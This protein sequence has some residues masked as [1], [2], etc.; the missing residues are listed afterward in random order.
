MENRINQQIKANEVRLVSLPENYTDGVYPIAKAI[1]I[2]NILN[3]DLIEISPNSTPPVCKIMEFSKFLYEKKK[4]EKENK[5]NQKI[6]HLKEIGL[7]P[8]IGE[9]DLETKARKGNEFLKNGDKIKVVLLFKGRTIVFKER[10]ELTM[11]KY[12]DLLKEL[13]VPEAMPKLEGKRMSFII[14][15]KTLAK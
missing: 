7:S 12:A 5:K 8:D 3:L 14:R 2:S 13:G 11:L 6:S 10:G 9:H 4:K 1:E 15:P